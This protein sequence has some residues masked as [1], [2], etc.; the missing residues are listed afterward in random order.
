M[1]L[2]EKKIKSLHSGFSECNS[3]LL[4]AGFTVHKSFINLLKS[5]VFCEF[6][7][8]LNWVKLDFFGQ[9]ALSVCDDSF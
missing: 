3:R 5:K 9:L 6:L 8:Y 2:V 4:T 1:R 7:L